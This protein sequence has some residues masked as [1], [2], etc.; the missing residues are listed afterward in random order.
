ML[1]NKKIKFS[2]SEAIIKEDFYA[3]DKT[4]VL[5]VNLRFPQITCPKTDPLFKTA[6]PFYK[7]LADSFYGYCKES[8][9]PVA[10]KA[11]KESQGQ[12]N[13][14]SAVMQWENTFLSEKHLSVLQK[15]SVSNGN[16]PPVTAVKT[17][18]WERQKGTKCSVW[19][20]ISKTNINELL[21][22]YPHLNKKML[23]LQLFTLCENGVTVY[24][25]KGNCTK[26]N[27]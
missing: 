25:L 24:D 26:I 1:F 9:L 16:T 11:Y 7:N 17:Q 27:T 19:D 3:D 15:I 20:F 18:V 2:V 4:A 21:A 23:G 8:L 22:K 6:A 10:L 5:R 12:F 14:Y 13:P